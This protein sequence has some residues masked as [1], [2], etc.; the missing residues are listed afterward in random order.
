[1][2]GSKQR[3]LICDVDDLTTI[4]RPDAAA[5]AIKDRSLVK[6][7]HVPVATKGF[8]EI[9]VTKDTGSVKISPMGAADRHSFKAVGK[10]LHP[11][12]SDEILAFI[13]QAI[14][15]RYIVLFTLPGS[16]ELIQLGSDEFQVDIMPDYDTTEN[17]G[18][19]R[20]TTFNFEVYMPAIWKYTA[21]VPLLGAA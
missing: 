17:G 21:A 8:F 7:P 1:M 2:G 3:I 19:G 18:D 14:N 5:V 13:N 12:E 10:F 4:A 16:N 20:G 6:T 11:G 15:S 9:Y